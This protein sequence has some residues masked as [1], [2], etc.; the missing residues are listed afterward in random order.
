MSVRIYHNRS[1]YI[2]QGK[3]RPEKEGIQK[4]M[5]GKGKELFG[6]LHIC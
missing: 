2:L 4:Y 5:L 3:Y 1:G 6:I